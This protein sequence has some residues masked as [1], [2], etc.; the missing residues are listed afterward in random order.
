MSTIEDLAGRTILVTGASGFIGSHLCAALLHAGAEVHG[1][2]RQQQDDDAIQWSQG[3][4]GQEADVER[5]MAD[6]KPD[7]V[8][9][10]ASFVAGTRALA[11]VRTAFY[12]NLASTVHLMTAASQQGVDRFITVGSLEEPSPGEAESIPAS[13]YAAAKGAAASYAKMFHALYDFPV[14]HLRVFMVYGPAQQDLRKLIPYVI[15]ESLQGRT[16]ELSSGVREVDWIYVSDVVDAMVAAGTAPG[17]D[18]SSIDVGTGTLDTIRT[19][20]EKLVAEVDR[21]ITPQFGAV[22]DRPM[23]VVRRADVEESFRQL[24]WRPQVTLDE[25]LQRTAAWYAAALK[26]GSVTAP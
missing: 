9:H 6:V 12:G 26:E 15:L 1:V 24:G 18:G 19:V 23:E 25:G 22:G 20:V 13:P 3:D 17:V 10:L 11:A 7:I 21:A 14:V 16:P 5:I 8:Y 2:S 4:M